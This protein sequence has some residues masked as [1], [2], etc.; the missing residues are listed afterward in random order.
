[1]RKRVLSGPESADPLENSV[2]RF[3]PITL[4][5][6]DMLD[7]VVK[8]EVTKLV[9]SEIGHVDK[10]TIMRD[11]LFEASFIPYFNNIMLKNVLRSVV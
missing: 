5:A 1:M 7:S 4:V 9:K 6:R 2:R 8:E 11:Y 3:D 10:D